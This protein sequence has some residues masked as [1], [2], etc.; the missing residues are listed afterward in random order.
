[1]QFIFATVHVKDLEDSIRFYEQTVGL[2]LIRRFFG[3]PGIDIAFLADG[4]AELELICDK[5]AGCPVHGTDLSLGFLTEDLD[6]AMR[7]ME[8]QGVAIAAGPFQ[9]NPSARFFFIEDP[10]GVRVQIIEQK[11]R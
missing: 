9:P 10:N 2:R 1:M 8:M 5:N 4:P 11:E 6:Q 3:G 7:D